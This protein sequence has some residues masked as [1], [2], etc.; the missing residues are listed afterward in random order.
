MPAIK[1]SFDQ[2][3]AS[4]QERIKEIAAFRKCTIDEV[5]QGLWDSYVSMM[6]SGDPDLTGFA[7]EVQEQS[8][9]AHQ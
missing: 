9:A 6:V 3:S 7:K 5:V 1:Y 8:G 4:K 2:F